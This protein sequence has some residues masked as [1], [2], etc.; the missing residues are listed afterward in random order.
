[1]SSFL[2]F[3]RTGRLGN[4]RCGM[5]LAQFTEFLGHAS[6]PFPTPRGFFHWGSGLVNLTFFR[7]PDD[8]DAILTSIK[9]KPRHADEPVHT[10]FDW[11]GADDEP[12]MDFDRFRG[13]LDGK[14]VRT[15][16]G[17]VLGTER[18]LVLESGV[19]AEF[20]EEGL[21]TVSF[22]PKRESESRQ[23]T[24]NLGKSDLELIKREATARGLSVSK[25][26]SEW[27]REHATRIQ[28]VESI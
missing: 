3:L 18:H 21:H 6:E 11:R 19:R 25:I 23:I 9:L 17:N 22:T 8:V 15:A 24:V 12:P 10:A 16:G 27:I 14:G 20:D 2:E 5:S 4:V 28:R 1:M 26:C 13:W 7:K